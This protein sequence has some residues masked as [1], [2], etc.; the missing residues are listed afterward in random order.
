M[1]KLIFYNTLSRK[2]EEFKPIISDHAGLYTCGPTVYNYA[3]LG[4][5]RAYIFEDVLKRVL[6]YNGY[7]VRH[8]MN[9]TDVGH[10]TGDMDMGEDKM[11]KKARAD[12]KNIWEIAAFYTDA[13]KKDLQALNIIEPDVWLKATETITEQIA[14]VKIL[15]EKGFTYKTSDG[16]YFD[17]SRFPAYGRLSHLDL[18]TLK[19]GARVE[20]NQEKKHPTDFALWKFSPR[21]EKRQME[22]PSLWGIGFP[23]WHLECSVMSALGLKEM[24]DIHCGGVDHIN[25]HHTNEI[26]QY[27]AAYGRKFF[28]YWL[29]NEFLNITGGKKM[30]K[31]AGNF[32]TL[33][34]SLRQKNLPP[35]AYRFAALQTHY[36]KPM[37]YSEES[38]ANASQSF[39]HLRRQIREIKSTGPEGPDG[40]HASGRNFQADFQRAINDDLNTPKALAVAQEMLKSELPAA[41]KLALWLDF[42]RVLGLGI[43]GQEDE[44]SPAVQALARERE[45]ARRKKDFGRSDELRRQLEDMGY[46]V[47]DQKDGQKIFKR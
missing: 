21:G 2:K 44:I 43:S 6:L 29:H 3:H 39:L 31:S 27:E 7:Q 13:F 30:A 46:E 15:E 33:D 25:V 26:A 37:E 23:G 17:T 42:D 28:N 34:N 22:W 9:I 47:A 38:L 19:E 1:E 18:E 20:K 11:E 5:L 14:L 24:R 4:N 10:L 35:L 40:G 45:E 12:K 32:L 41:V 16:I 8:V 36:R